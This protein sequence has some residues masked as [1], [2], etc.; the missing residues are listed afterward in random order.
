MTRCS[1]GRTC[2][3]CA[4]TCVTWAPTRRQT[5]TMTTTRTLAATR[6]CAIRT[7]TSVCRVVTDAPAPARV[8]SMCVLRV[9]HCLHTD[10]ILPVYTASIL[11]YWKRILATPQNKKYCGTLNI[12]SYR[13]RQKFPLVHTGRRIC[14]VHPGVSL[15][16]LCTGG[17]RHQGGVAPDPD[18]D[19]RV[20]SM[21]KIEKRVYNHIPKS[22]GPYIW[23]HT[24]SNCINCNGTAVFSTVDFE[25]VWIFP[26]CQ[27]ACRILPVSPQAPYCQYSHTA[28][29][30]GNTGSINIILEA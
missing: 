6:P 20:D 23:S 19:A 13:A 5:Q 12:F 29:M 10:A 3:V 14:R 21:E 22:V 16:K 26:Y 11:A 30:V 2:T 9:K 28:S 24:E 4:P 17:A 18:F 7:P 8:F 15:D 1:R 27:Y 25:P